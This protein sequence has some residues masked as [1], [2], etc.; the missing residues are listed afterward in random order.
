VAEVKREGFPHLIPAPTKPATSRWH[1]TAPAPKVSVATGPDSLAFVETPKPSHHKLTPRTNTPGKALATTK[2]VPSTSVNQSL[3]NRNTS[4][5]PSSLPVNTLQLRNDCLGTLVH[6]L[7]NAFT[8]T[9]SWE[10]FVAEFRGPSYL[11]NELDNIE[12]PAA[13]LLRKWRDHGVPVK[14][15]SEPWS[16]DQKDACIQRGCH[17]SAKDHAAFVREEMAEFVES[18]F[19]VVLP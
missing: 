3:S 15:T 16:S 12:H 14:T 5:N 7:T 18:K 11:A 13:E 10:N 6:E 9:A 4:L 2:Y 19:W 8:N 1:A 17:K